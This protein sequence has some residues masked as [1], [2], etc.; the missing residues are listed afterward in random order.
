MILTSN[1]GARHLT[2]RTIAP[3]TEALVLEDVRA[4]LR[5]E[6]I[7]RLDDVIM[8]H[9]LSDQDLDQILGLMLKQENRL[10]AT[11]G[12]ELRFSG[13]ARAWMLGRNDEPQY[14]ARP[15]RRIIRRYVREPL[16]DYLL[17]EIRNRATSSTL[18]HRAK[19]RLNSNSPGRTPSAA[20]RTGSAT[21]TLGRRPAW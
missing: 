16:A 3:E 17:R 21:Q 5:P 8:F 6:F 18:M 12:L 4:H 15:L 1:L 14:G 10:A 2:D 13:K 9:P 7:N 19:P 11:R 20:A